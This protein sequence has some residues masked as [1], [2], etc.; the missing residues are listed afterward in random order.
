LLVCVSNAQK[1][2]ILAQ[3]KAIEESS[4]DEDQSG[5]ICDLGLGE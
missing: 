3:L 1:R 5:Q 2:R 4:N